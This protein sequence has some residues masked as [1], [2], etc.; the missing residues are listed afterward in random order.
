MDDI[1]CENNKKL[2]TFTTAFIRKPFVF[3]MTE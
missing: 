1:C 2:K 3:A